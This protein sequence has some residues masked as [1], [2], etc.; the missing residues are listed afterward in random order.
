MCRWEKCSH[1]SKGC[2][3]GRCEL[4]HIVDMISRVYAVAFCKLSN[5][6][7]RKLFVCGYD[8]KDERAA[9]QFVDLGKAH[10][11]VV[12][13]LVSKCSPSNLKRFAPYRF[14]KSSILISPFKFYTATGSYH[15]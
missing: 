2:E 11:K 7:K 1:S 5:K 14:L 8:G 13:S 9:M 3:G 10:N 4:N 12:S 15:S 6:V